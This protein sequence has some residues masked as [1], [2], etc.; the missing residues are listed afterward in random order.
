M[1]ALTGG[2]TREMVVCRQRGAF[3]CMR[4]FI[5][6]HCGGGRGAGGGGGEGLWGGGAGVRG[7][8]FFTPGDVAPCRRMLSFRT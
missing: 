6:F 5:I 8:A 1:S 4:I 2:T 3:R 7:G